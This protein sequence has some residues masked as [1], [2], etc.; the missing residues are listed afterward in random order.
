MKFRTIFSLFLLTIISSYG[1]NNW[2]YGELILRNNDT[3]KGFIQIPMINRAAIANSQKIKFKENQGGKTIRYDYTSAQKLIFKGYDGEISLFEYI[4]TSQSKVQLFKRIYTGNKI[5]LYGR[6][7]SE[8][9]TGQDV[10]GNMTSTGFYPTDYNEYYVIRKYERTA[11][12]LIKVGPFTKSFRK[13]AMKYFSDCP[14]LVTKLKNRT[15]S[16]SDLPRIVKEYDQC[17]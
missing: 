9:F 10:N 2:K 1:Q 7:V 5:R 3:L 17:K 6:M 8:V 16:E 15:L 13:S 4:R 11:T 12:P 14:D